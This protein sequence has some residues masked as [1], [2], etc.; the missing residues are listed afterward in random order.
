MLR[1][2]LIYFNSSYDKYE[3]EVPYFFPNFAFNQYYTYDYCCLKDIMNILDQRLLSV[4][5]D[6][7]YKIHVD[8]PFCIVFPTPYSWVF[9]Y[10]DQTQ[11][12]RMILNCKCTV[13]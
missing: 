12:V 8:D 2:Y 13:C 1:D 6:V 5:K 9:C 3:I 7:G 10:C 11:W 4:V